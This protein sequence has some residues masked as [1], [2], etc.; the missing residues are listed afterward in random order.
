[1]TD[2]D[3]FG[4]ILRDREKAAEDRYMAEQD[5]LRL[6][7]IREKS[8]SSHAEKGVCPSCSTPLAPAVEQDVEVKACP[9][10]GG[11]WLDAAALEAFVARAREGEIE[12]FVRSLLR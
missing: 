9:G 5:R 12:R 11:V 3:R 2:K 8:R 10:C 6:E 7:K 4:E 1:M